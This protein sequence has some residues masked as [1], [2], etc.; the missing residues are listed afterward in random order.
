MS[1]TI[2][3]RLDESI[4]PAAA[5]A[6]RSERGGRAKRRGGGV[7]S[8]GR[9]ELSEELKA[10]LPDELRD[11]APGAGRCRAAASAPLLR[12]RRLRGAHRA[13]AASRRALHGCFARSSPGLP[14]MR[15]LPGRGRPR[16][17]AP[18]RSDCA[19]RCREARGRVGIAPGRRRS[20]RR[21]HALPRPRGGLLVRGC[22]GRRCRR[23]RQRAARRRRRL[24]PRDR[25]VR[26]LWMLRSSN[27]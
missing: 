17:G 25:L 2:P 3:S 22:Y 6:A 27:A 14:T 12:R 16:P 21:V 26:P 19:R 24:L 20:V 8:A 13:V 15:Y 9:P 11:E 1:S 4:D 23:A 18:R 7:R 10:L 5:G